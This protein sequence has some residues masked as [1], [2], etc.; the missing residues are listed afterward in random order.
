MLM[1]KPGSSK[2]TDIFRCRPD[3]MAQSSRSRT[4]ESRST[5]GACYTVAS[6]S[7]THPPPRDGQGRIVDLFAGEHPS[8]NVGSNQR[9][10]HVRTTDSVVLKWVA[11]NLD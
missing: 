5:F 7:L 10:V 1:A 9:C 4:N 11:L 3:L 2:N 8:S 6:L